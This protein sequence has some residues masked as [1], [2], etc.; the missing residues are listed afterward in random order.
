MY[1]FK[2][3]NKVVVTK[4][5]YDDGILG[6]E[7]FVIDASD[8]PGVSLFGFNH[9]HSLHNRLR[10]NSGWYIDGTCLRLIDDT[11]FEGNV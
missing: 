11:P 9:G 4:D 1:K 5:L 7:G 6:L 3:G 10:D 8:N 2:L